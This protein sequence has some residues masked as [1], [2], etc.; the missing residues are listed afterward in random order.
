MA[1]LNPPFSVF[2]REPYVEALRRRASA[3]GLKE[4]EAAARMLED[5]LEPFLSDR[6]ATAQIAAEREILSIAEALAREKAAD[7]N[8]S[9]DLML[10]V[11]EEIRRHHLDLYRAATAEGQDVSVNRRIGRHIK[12]AVGA[13]VKTTSDGRPITA[14]V[15]RSAG[16]LISRY[17][18]LKKS[19]QSFS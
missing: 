8:F 4:A 12:A 13:E 9:E 17:S 7:G 10:V 6:N 1:K 5:A 19:K 18:L 11:F 16:A 14:K 3:V 2:L 15:R